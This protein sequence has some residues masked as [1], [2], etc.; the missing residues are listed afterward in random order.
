MQTDHFT[1]TGADAAPIRGDLYLPDA[2]RPPLVVVI[3]GFKGF[4]DWGFFPWLGQH[5][6]QAGLAAACINL[7]HCGI[8]TNP[9][10]FERLDLFERD[11]WSKRL[12]DIQQVLE[13]AQHGLLTDKGEP[14]PSRLGMLGHSM[15][16]CAALL[17]AAKDARVRSIATLAGV[18]HANR[19]PDGI[20]RD[21]LAALG[22]VA[23]EN[24]RTKQT[25]RIG[26]EFFE[27]VWAHAEAFD[28]LVAARALNVPWLIVHGA[29]DETVPLEE[30]HELLDAANGG[31]QNGENVR[32]LTLDG[33]G[34]TFD[35]GHPFTG[36]SVMLERAADAIASHFLRTL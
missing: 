11:T 23:I 10:T 1:L 12:F 22:H 15:G 16:G 25:M 8:G 31:S 32:M 7:S 21:Q 9:E 13:A 18:A 5:L 3:H 30:A 4:K 17:T 6:A 2:P 14:N 19:I 28:I 36:P 20:A 26:R 35:A 27:E 24:A 29:D 34:H 33:T